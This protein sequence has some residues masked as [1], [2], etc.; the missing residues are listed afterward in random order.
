MYIIDASCVAMSA[1]RAAD[2]PLGSFCW[3]YSG[4]KIDTLTRARCQLKER[5]ALDYR[6]VSEGG[7]TN[8]SMFLRLGKLTTIRFETYIIQL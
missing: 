5:S 1:S 3:R 7:G 2:D 6:K 4:K 8:C